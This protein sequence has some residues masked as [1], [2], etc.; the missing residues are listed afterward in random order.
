MTADASTVDALRQ[1][2]PRASERNAPRTHWAEGRHLVE[3]GDPKDLEER[4][5][6]RFPTPEALADF[7]PDMK[8]S[9]YGFL[10][11]NRA[12]GTA[13]ATENVQDLHTF[14]PTS[15]SDAVPLYHSGHT[16]VC[17]RM[18]EHLPEAR[19]RGADIL[20]ALG[21]PHQPVATRGLLDPWS[22][23]WPFVLSMVYT[24]AGVG[25]GLGL[26][27]D[28]FDSVVV[29]VRG[30]KRWRVGR[31]PFL[32]Y[33]LYNEELAARLDFPPSLPRMGTQSELV[34]D[35]EVIEMRRGSA[36]IMP[37]GIYHTTLADD[38]ASLSLGYH[39]SLPT[40]SHVVL[41]ALERRLTCDPRMRTTP[42][43]AFGPAGP[44][45]EARE[46]MAWA[47]ERAREALDDPQK[48][49]EEDLLGN[50]ASHH[51][52]AFQVEPDASA[53]LLIAE[54]PVVV[55]YGGQGIDVELPAAAAGL[56]GWMLAGAPD[57]FGFAE[58]LAAAERQL[59]PRAVWN[60]LQQC[61]EAGLLRRR[62][63]SPSR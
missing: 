4:I 24:P 54:P 25:S 18:L 28:R 35:L 57:W 20:E 52:A 46:G 48:L 50:L 44:S 34:T 41:A 16:I 36:L 9:V 56:C 32:E 5:A 8:V 39:F 43:D 27:Y 62:W 17:W 49:L 3:H 31:H 14:P 33:P 12:E 37:R 2:F 30:H 40:W 53:R 29:H 61:V 15:I 13:G 38:E 26:H 60:L 7:A 22:S 10:D 6:E 58:A 1:L 45:A 51:Q 55:D 19:Q 23:T 63:G 59:S 11:K 47:A 42:L 21:L